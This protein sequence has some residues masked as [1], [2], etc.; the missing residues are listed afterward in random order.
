MMEINNKL[1]GGYERFQTT[2]N[3]KY[4]QLKLTQ[5]MDEYRSVPMQISATR[6]LGRSILDYAKGYIHHIQDWPKK[7]SSWQ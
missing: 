7:A 3:N 1:S 2:E 4:D 6:I 5:L